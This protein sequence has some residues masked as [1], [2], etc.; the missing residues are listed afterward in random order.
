MRPPIRPVTLWPKLK[1]IEPTVTKNI[2]RIKI[3][4]VKYEKKLTQLKVANGNHER[5]NIP[6]LTNEDAKK[7]CLKSTCKSAKNEKTHIVITAKHIT[8]IEI[9]SNEII[10]IHLN[11]WNKI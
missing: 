6:P 7:N 8:I 10:S 5:K 3:S 1:F 4:T 2:K 9:S 11:K